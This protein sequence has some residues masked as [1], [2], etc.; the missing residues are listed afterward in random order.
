VLGVV[1]MYIHTKMIQVCNGCICDTH[2]SGC[3]EQAVVNNAGVL[4]KASLN[5]MLEGRLDMK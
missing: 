4:Q 3:L 1:C 2:T 5:C